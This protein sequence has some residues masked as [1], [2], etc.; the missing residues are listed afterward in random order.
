LLT[1]QAA[2][3]SMIPRGGKIITLASQVGRR[4]EA[5]VAEATKAAAFSPTRPTGLDLI[6]NKI[7]VNAFAPRAVDCERRDHV[8]QL[9]AKTD[10][11]AKTR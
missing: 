7:S 2:A 5:L 3:C 11:S 9:F 1:L 4:G 10:R 8:D 6:K